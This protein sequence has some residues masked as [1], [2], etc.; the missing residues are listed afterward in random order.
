MAS[1]TVR[2]DERLIELIYL[3]TKDVPY[4]D[5]AAHSLLIEA[6]GH[7]N[8]RIRKAAVHQI[9]A[10]ATDD[11]RS[12]LLHRLV[13][14]PDPQ[15]RS[16]ATEAVVAIGRPMLEAIIET[17]A[18]KGSDRKILIDILGAIGD[19]RAIPCLADSCDDP[20]PNIEMASAEALGRIADARAIPPLV[21]LTTKSNF[22]VAAAAA[23]ALWCIASPIP[24]DVVEKL[25][26]N[27]RLR[28]SAV[29]LSGLTASPKAVPIIIDALSEK[30]RSIRTAAL[31]AAVRLSTHSAPSVGRLLVDALHAAME[32]IRPGIE[33]GLESQD[34]DERAAAAKVAT[35][36]V[37][38]DLL[39]ALLTAATNAETEEAA[40][41]AVLAMDLA[42]AERLGPLLASADRDLRGLLYEI[43]ARIPPPRWME[44]RSAEL[45]DGSLAQSI[46][47]GIIE[48][49]D[50]ADPELATVAA[51]AL[52]T[53]GERQAVAALTRTASG[54]LNEPGIAPALGQ[55]LGTLYSRFPSE[56]LDA[57]TAIKDERMPELL[58]AMARTMQRPELVEVTARLA[59]HSDTKL[60]LAAMDT[61]RELPPSPLG[62]Q[63]LLEALDDD[64]PRVRAAAAHAAIAGQGHDLEALLL[65]KLADRE[66]VVRAAAASTLGHMG[67]VEAIG[68]ME[69]LIVRE[70]SALV[71]ISVLAAFESMAV[72][73]DP[74]VLLATCDRPEPDVLQAA[75]STAC[76][77]ISDQRLAQA[78]RRLANHPQWHVRLAAVAA[79]EHH[80]EPRIL[81]VDLARIQSK[82]TDDLVLSRVHIIQ[83]RL[84][85]EGRL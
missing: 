24:F 48:D 70:P 82:E 83:E 57:L 51:R 4:G 31:A 81:P 73:P 2:D 40:I 63:L 62:T 25:M 13:E 7:E 69:K 47:A 60:R 64:D 74:A 58:P 18:G 16:A 49:L 23:E 35:W 36:T 76:L 10:L 71:T 53:F 50:P 19:P 41:K 52:G 68:P 9:V 79:L 55:A 33:A 3:T 59:A 28:R 8:L 26:T 17:C 32:A 42:F 29:K 1:D 27:R 66:E 45:H 44:H 46:E 56:V 30:V 61:L 21:Q 38:P 67:I 85:Q 12:A 14:T 72:A 11:L 84:R 22:M 15:T 43:I 34:P 5:G 80:A 77:A 75:L 65:E 78:A 54:P 6:L 39:P 20:D 37:D